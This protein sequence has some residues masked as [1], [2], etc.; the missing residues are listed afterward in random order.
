[1]SEGWR[2]QLTPHAERDIKRLDPP[3][4]AR[5]FAVLDRLLIDP[6]ACDIVKLQGHEQRQ[7]MC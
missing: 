6:A 7:R 3:T 2:Y 4:R 1:M 5:L